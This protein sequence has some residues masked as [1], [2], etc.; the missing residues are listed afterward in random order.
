MSE[1]P[2]YMPSGSLRG[3]G[4]ARTQANVFDQCGHGFLTISDT[5]CRDRKYTIV[6]QEAPEVQEEEPDFLDRPFMPQVR[7]WS[8]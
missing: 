6:Y 3:A 2:L 1:V 4:R 7:P 8:H 5:R